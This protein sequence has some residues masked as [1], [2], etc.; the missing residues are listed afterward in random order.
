LLL[1]DDVKG[2]Y[3]SAPIRAAFRDL[4]DGSP[5]RQ[6]IIDA[7]YRYGDPNLYENLERYDCIPFLHGVWRK[8]AAASIQAMN[9][10]PDVFNNDIDIC[11]YH[12]HEADEEKEACKKE[13]E[14]SKKCKSCKEST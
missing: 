10:D 11:D 8:Y 9:G 13:Q 2:W 12:N 6:L 3:G 4:R 7:H 5:M 14:Q 1:S